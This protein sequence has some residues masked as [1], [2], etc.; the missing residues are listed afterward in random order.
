M[1]D[2]P[3]ARY[4]TDTAVLAAGDAIEAVTGYVTDEAVR[5]ALLAA[6]AIVGPEIR[7]EERERCAAVAEGE[8]DWP[9]NIDSPTAALRNEGRNDAAREIAA[10]IRAL[11]KEG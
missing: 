7:R 5:S 10:A 4:V 3:F 8:A 6:L 2:N 11:G 9:E 1:T